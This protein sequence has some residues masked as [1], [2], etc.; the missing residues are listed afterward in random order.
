MASTSSDS[1]TE[2][3]PNDLSDEE[4]NG[5][6]NGLTIKDENTTGKWLPRHP[7]G[8]ENKPDPDLEMKDTVDISSKYLVFPKWAIKDS[9]TKKSLNTKKILSNLPMFVEC[10]MKGSTNGSRQELE[11]IVFRHY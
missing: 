7:W 10:E 5:K 8:S 4:L 11:R 6:L 1:E 9:G 2:T 3:E